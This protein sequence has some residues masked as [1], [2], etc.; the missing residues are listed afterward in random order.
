MV[1]LKLFDDWKKVFVTSWSNR[2][3]AVNAIVLALI[4]AWPTAAVDIWNVLPD[5][6]KAYVPQN[7]AI[8]IPLTLTGLSMWA[9]VVIQEKMANGGK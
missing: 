7:I 1:S 8:I 5:F 6:L 9:R 2:I 4:A 3:N